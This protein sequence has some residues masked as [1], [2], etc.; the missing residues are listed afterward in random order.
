MLTS[1]GKER[2][3]VEEGRG[4]DRLFDYFVDRRDAMF[5]FVRE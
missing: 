5:E 4:G 2:R 1:K 3:R